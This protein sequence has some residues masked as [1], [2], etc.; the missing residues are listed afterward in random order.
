M[1]RH[2]HPVHAV[3]R[4]LAVHAAGGGSERDAGDRGGLGRA[5]A[6]DD[7]RDAAH[8]VGCPRREVAEGVEA[9]DQGRVRVAAL[10][11]I[12]RAE[13]P[14]LRAWVSAREADGRRVAGLPGE[15]VLRAPRVSISAQGQRHDMRGGG[16]VADQREQPQDVRRQPSAVAASPEP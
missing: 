15:H 6:D 16:Q 9:H 8:V 10:Q 3:D 14:G 7:R 2:G 4:G 12:D 5:R 1:K 11:D 13:L